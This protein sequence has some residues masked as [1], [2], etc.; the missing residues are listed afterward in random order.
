MTDYR[1]NPTGVTMLDVASELNASDPA[2]GRGGHLDYPTS[3]I[4]RTERCP[5]CE[6]SG[7]EWAEVDGQYEAVAECR[8]CLGSGKGDDAAWIRYNAETERARIA[9]QRTRRAIA[10]AFSLE[11]EREAAR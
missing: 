7:E 11:R 5:E 2:E 3:D 1:I 10:L 4:E 8:I 9:A 6:G